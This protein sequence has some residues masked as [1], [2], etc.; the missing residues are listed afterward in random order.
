M[1]LYFGQLIS[2]KFITIKIVTYDYSICFGY[3]FISVFYYTQRRTLTVF[4]STLSYSCYFY[5]PSKLCERKETV[6]TKCIP[7]TLY[8]VTCSISLFKYRCLYANVVC[9]N[10]IVVFCLN[11]L[12][13]VN[14]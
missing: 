9:I 8:F 13:C 6:R 10:T 12:T 2:D 14:E 1:Y 7:I 4:Y 3:I 11:E 5:F